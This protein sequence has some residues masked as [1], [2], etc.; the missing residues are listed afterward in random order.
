MLLSRGNRTWIHEVSILL[1]SFLLKLPSNHLRPK[2]I[3]FVPEFQKILEKILLR[4]IFIYELR[5]G[6][7]KDLSRVIIN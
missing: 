6:L 4:K 7:K 1:T 3:P 2:Y 5:F